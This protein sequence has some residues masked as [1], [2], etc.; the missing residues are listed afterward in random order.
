MAGLRSLF[1]LRSR[2]SSWGLWITPYFEVFERRKGI[3]GEV[4]SHSAGM[5]YT[6]SNSM[7]LTRLRLL[8]YILACASH[9]EIG[10]SS[11]R[12]HPGTHNR[13]SKWDKT[14]L[15][16]S[17]LD[18]GRASKGTP[19]TTKTTGALPWGMCD[20]TTTASA[21]QPSLRHQIDRPE[22]RFETVEFQ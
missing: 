15:R 7:R 2:R 9:Q 16:Y 6:P 19:G 1:D 8:Q 17:L 10:F 12:L 11:F 18:S 5:H 20:R 14:K 13:H 22:L 4:V 21:V 3:L